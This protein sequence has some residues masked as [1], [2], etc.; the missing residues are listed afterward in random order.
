MA[1]ERS[2]KKSFQ[3]SLEDI[4]KWMKE[5]RNKNL[6]EMKNFTPNRRNC[7]KLGNMS[8]WNGLQ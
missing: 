1:K 7:S 5:N 8:L 3:D 6:P 4:K 2:L